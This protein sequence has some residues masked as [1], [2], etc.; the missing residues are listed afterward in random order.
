MATV[1]RHRERALS[2]F[3]PGL[4]ATKRDYWRYGSLISS[5]GWVNSYDPNYSGG[6]ETCDDHVQLSYPVT[7]HNLN[8]NKRTAKAGR[9]NGS[10]STPAA[11]PWLGYQWHYQCTGRSALRVGDPTIAGVGTLP[12]SDWDALKNAALARLNVAKPTVDF[13]LVMY[14]MKD[15]PRMLRDLMRVLRREVK[16]SDVPNGWLAFQFGWRP[17]IQELMAYLSIVDSI[18]HK[19]RTFQ[20]VRLGKKLKG[21]L[22]KENTL[23]KWRTY[24]EHEIFSVGSGAAK[25]SVVVDVY[26]DYTESAWFTAS[27]EVVDHQRLSELLQLYSYSGGPWPLLYRELGIVSN[28]DTLWNAIPWSF[29]IDY[30]ANF[31][32]FFTTMRGILPFRVKSLCIMHNKKIVDK[33]EVVSNT[34]DLTYDPHEFVYEDKLRTVHTYPSPAIPRFETILTKGQMA[35]IA[36]LLMARI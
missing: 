17:L 33:S 25:V 3:S 29:L 9:L 10:G 5:T 32:D 6:H 1:F 4:L 21:T 22:I 23:E 14:E 30:F 27:T 15:F 24:G 36:A 35:N 2:T 16:P 11:Q 7:D 8:L 34:T 12:A 26:Q 28:L 19:L 18:D 31:S 20:K 13:P